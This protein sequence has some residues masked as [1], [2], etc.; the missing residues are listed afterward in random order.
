MEKGADDTSE[1]VLNPAE[2]WEYSAARVNLKTMAVY[3][4]AQRAEVH[5]AVA[6]GRVRYEHNNNRLLSQSVCWG[7]AG[8]LFEGV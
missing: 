4:L 3:E 6:A 5:M 1:N 7:R 2:L 8:R